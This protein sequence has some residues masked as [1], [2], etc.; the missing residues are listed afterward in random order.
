MLLTEIYKFGDSCIDYIN[1]A[2]KYTGHANNGI[3]LYKPI[4][5]VTILLVIK[6]E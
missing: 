3:S 2:Y 4:F 5:L 1:I 6:Q